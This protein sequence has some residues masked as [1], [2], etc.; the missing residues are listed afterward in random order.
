MPCELIAFLFV[1]VA[2]RSGP[3]SHN[4]CDLI[5]LELEYN[6]LIM[7][8]SLNLEDYVLSDSKF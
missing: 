7:C 2:A 1:A 6:F 3:A 4:R 5:S 8:R